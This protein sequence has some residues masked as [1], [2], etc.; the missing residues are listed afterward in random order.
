MIFEFV[1]GY[2]DIYLLFGKVAD[3]IAVDAD[4]K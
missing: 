1:D 2:G 4:T 3:A